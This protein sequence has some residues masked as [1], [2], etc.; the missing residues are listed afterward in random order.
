M[1]ALTVNQIGSLQDFSNCAN[2]KELYLRRNNIPAKVSQI[3]HLQNLGK[4]RV[5][6]L[7][8]NPISTALP[9]YRL[10]AIKLLPKLEKLDDIPITPKERQQAMGYNEN[11]GDNNNKRTFV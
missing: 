9:N 11:E 5:L 1:I 10:A 6:N 4:L 2:L 3:K 7:L 8:E